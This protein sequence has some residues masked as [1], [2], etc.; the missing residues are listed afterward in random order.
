MLKGRGQGGYEKGRRAPPPI[1]AVLLPLPG[2]KHPLLTGA[3]PGVVHSRLRG[4]R[5]S[6]GLS[7]PARERP[8]HEAPDRRGGGREGHVAPA[9]AHLRV[10]SS[11]LG[12]L[13]PGL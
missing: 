11:S 4:S 7:L 12:L 8:G 3:Q 6:S 13:G 5:P 2:N 9:S 1:P 10:T